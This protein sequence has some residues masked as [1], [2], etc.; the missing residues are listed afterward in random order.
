MLFVQ[1]SGFAEDISP[2]EEFKDLVS[3]ISDGL[4]SP[5]V[6]LTPYLKDSY[7]EPGE[8][9]RKYAQQEVILNVGVANNKEVVKA[10]LMNETKLSEDERA[11]LYCRRLGYIDTKNFATMASKSEF[12]NFPKLKVLNEDNIGSDLAKHKRGAYKRNDRILRKRW[13][14]R[15]GGVFK[16]M[17]MGVKIQ[18]KL[19][20][21][22]A[23]RGHIYLHAFPRVQRISDYM[24]V[25]IS[26][27][28]HCIN[29]WYEFKRNS[30]PIA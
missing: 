22:K 16:L 19:Y 1:T 10:M 17:A 24:L 13:L 2:S 30:G 25:I 4:E 8:R 5:L 6:D 11:R 27:Q 20:L 12:G 28:L 29:F 21:K 23:R 15:R 18:W 9:N 26:S 3:K 7:S 14:I